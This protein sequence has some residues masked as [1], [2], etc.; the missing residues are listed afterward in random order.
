MICRVERAGGGRWRR[1]RSDKEFR[2]HV[3]I[4]LSDGRPEALKCAPGRHRD[5]SRIASLEPS[6]KANPPAAAPACTAGPCLGAGF[7]GLNWGTSDPY[8]AANPTYQN[9]SFRAKMR[10]TSVL[11]GYEWFANMTGFIMNTLGLAGV[12]HVAYGFGGS[13]LLIIIDRFVGVT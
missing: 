8:R 4:D 11:C 13:M 12:L 6:R 2:T 10:L 3:C 1:E 5:E 9:S 7:W